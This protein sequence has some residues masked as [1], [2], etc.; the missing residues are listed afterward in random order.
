MT[1]ELALA[2]GNRKHAY[3]IHREQLQAS[4]EQNNT[5][6]RLMDLP[7]DARRIILGHS[8]DFQTL[9]AFLKNDRM[10]IRLPE[11]ARAGDSRLRRECLLV[12][13]NKCTMEIHSG[14]GNAALQ[15][16]LSSINFQGVDTSLETGFD[17]ITS[18]DFPYFSRF[19]YGRPDITSNN[20]VGLALSCK[21]LRDL[22]LNFHSEELGRVF[23]EHYESEG[24]VAAKSAL[25][26]RKNY[27]L[28]GLLGAEK[29]QTLSFNAYATENVMAGI[30]KVA[31]WFEQEFQKR[32]QKVVVIFI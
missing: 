16:W 3:A 32:G 13:L 30:H 21:N 18:L 2:I 12:A 15:G 26:V 7:Y 27:Q 19:P 28:D 11:V 25:S 14:P 9:R 17:A 8:I 22:K 1:Q 4:Q 23:Y 6:F 31:A 5:K 20:D 24:D 10:P 29:L